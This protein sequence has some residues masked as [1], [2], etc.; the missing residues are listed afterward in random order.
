MRALLLIVVAAAVLLP[1]SSEACSCREPGPPCETM[2]SSTVFVGTAV[3]TESTS[4]IGGATTFDV[5]ETLHAP[6]PLGKTVKVHHLLVSSICGLIFNPG[7][8]YVVYAD[9]VNGLLQAG[10]CSRTHPLAERDEDVTFARSNPSRERAV[11]QG[12]LV[13]AEGHERAPFKN[14]EV[15]VADA[16]ISAKVNAAGAFT[17]E[18]PPGRYRLDVTSQW[19]ERFG[20]ERS[21]LLAID[22][23]AACLKPVIMV[24]WN[25]KIRGKVTQANAPVAHVE[26]IAI[27]EIERNRHWRLSAVSGA[28][29]TF[30]ITGVEP[31]EYWVAVSAPD[32]G[33]PSAQSPYPPTWAP[34]AAKPSKAKTVRVE[35]SGTG[36]IDLQLPPRLPTYSLKVVVNGANGAP[37]KGAHVAVTPASGKRTAGGSTD[38]AGVV[39]LQEIGGV[40]LSIRACTSALKN[41]V[42]GKRTLTA[43]S[44]VELTLK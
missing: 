39:A 36:T 11:V 5:T 7:T 13:R 14:A 32:F 35:P 31:G 41:C 12:K 6:I 24:S 43:D 44:K 27:S 4:E 20:S 22:H 38:E 33:G 2:F 26:V 16:G 37:V 40:E 21:T 1:T 42:D 30:E 19:L 29:G 23:P 8:A 15:Q 28:D 17:L 10:A 18:L 9:E 3:K 34:N 25:G